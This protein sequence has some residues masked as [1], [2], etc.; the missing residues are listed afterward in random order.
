M[1]YLKYILT[2]FLVT[3]LSAVFGQYTLEVQ[4]F[5]KVIISPFIRVTFIED[6][7]ESVTIEA[8]RV[9]HEKLYIEVNGT[10]LRMY[11]EGAKELPN[12]NL[13]AFSKGNPEEYPDYEGTVVRAII[14]YKKLTDVSIRGEEPQH[15]A[16]TLRGD[17]FRL[18]VYGTSE[19][20]LDEVDLGECH[21]TIYGEAA[22]RIK[23]GHIDFQHY[24]VYGSGSINSLDING[25]RSKITSYGDADFRVNVSDRIKINSFGDVSVQYKGNALISWGIQLG[26]VRVNKL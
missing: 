11:L 3:T 20:V 23:A 12:V 15:F 26:E 17:A 4:S 13:N 22:L 5:D 10:T 2:S 19:V 6:T 14:R 7:H 8:C 21:A 18:K 9:E 16:S 24:V 25:S 1:Q